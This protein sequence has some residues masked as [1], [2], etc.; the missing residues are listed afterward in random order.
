MPAGRPRDLT[1]EIIV[2]AEEH[3]PRCLHLETVADLF[4]FSREAFFGWAR[5]G[6]R[7]LRRSERGIIARPGHGTQDDLKIRFHQGVRRGL[8][9]WV[10]TN[11]DMIQKA[12]E[13][14]WKAL[15]WLLAA[16]FPEQ[17]G[18]LSKLI[19]EQ[20]QELAEMRAELVRLRAES[21]QGYK[22]T[23]P[24]LEL[25]NGASCNGSH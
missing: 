17:F 23:P 4:G 15:A 10:S 25:T 2:A 12:G 24:R 22:E 14:Y 11:V 21:L 18:D 20:A 8:A 3:I 6:A 19:R 1:E 13:K 9:R 5:D 7:L 16:R